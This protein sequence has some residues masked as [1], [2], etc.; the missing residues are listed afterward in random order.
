MRVEEFD[1]TPRAARW[2]E[3]LREFA[4]RYRTTRPLLQAITPEQVGQR[5]ILSTHLATWID[6]EAARIPATHAIPF[7][8]SDIGIAMVD[9]FLTTPEPLIASLRQRIVPVRE[10]EYRLYTKDHPDPDLALHVNHW[11]WIKAPVPLQRHVEFRAWP[12]Q[13]DEVYWIH[14]TGTI[15]PG[16]AEYRHADLWKW[17]GSHAALLKPF[18][19]ERVDAL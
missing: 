11:S 19:Q 4:S 12:I 18:I 16:S 2:L 7:T 5:P 15:G 14:R 6:G 1:M 13:P 10:I 17:N 9:E 8:T 3:G